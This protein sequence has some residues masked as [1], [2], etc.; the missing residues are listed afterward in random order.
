MAPRPRAR[1]HPATRQEPT[2]CPS[3]G[4]QGHPPDALPGWAPY[5]TNCPQETPSTRS[6]RRFFQ[7]PPRRLNLQSAP[8][9]YATAAAVTLTIITSLP[10]LPPRGRW[11]PVTCVP[12]RRAALTALG[13]ER[14]TWVLQT[15]CR[16]GLVTPR[17]WQTHTVSW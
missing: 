14:D 3:L 16:K 4:P 6:R 2:T 13:R 1:R 11:C 10:V 8:A 5:S 12:L 17:W 7:A 9:G 15:T